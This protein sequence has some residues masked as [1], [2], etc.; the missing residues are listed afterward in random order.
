MNRTSELYLAIVVAIALLAAY[1]AT[2]GLQGAVAMVRFLGLTAFV[3]LCAALIIGPLAVLWPAQFAVL[4]EPRRAVGVSAFVFMLL[5]YLL[6]ISLYFKFNFAMVLNN[7]PLA[8]QIPSMVIFLAMA[9]TSTN[10]AVKTLGVA[11][12]KTL[13]RFVYLGFALTLAH[14]LLKS[15]GLPFIS[16]KAAGLNYAEVAVLLLGLATIGLQVAGFLAKSKRNAEAAK[17]QPAA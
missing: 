16:Q 10:W 14:F 8:I 6:V 4:I 9:L 13:H 12:W 5:H 3:L 11:K 15:N 2:L 7:F 17:Q 1:H